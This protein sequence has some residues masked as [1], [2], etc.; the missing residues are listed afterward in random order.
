MNV[1]PKF[2]AQSNDMSWHFIKIN[3]LH[4]HIMCIC[5]STHG[6]HI[7]IYIYSKAERKSTIRRVDIPL[8]S[9]NQLEDAV[10]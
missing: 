8:K 6:F 2:F 10:S 3:Q 4:M 9:I 1:I 7:Y 5:I